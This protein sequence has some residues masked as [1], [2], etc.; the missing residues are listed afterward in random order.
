MFNTLTFNFIAMKKLL[1]AFLFILAFIA[2][3]EDGENSSVSPESITIESA[4]EWLSSNTS[5]ARIG[6]TTILNDDLYWED[7]IVEKMKGEKKDKVVVV[8]VLF[9]RDSKLTT[10]KQIWIYDNN[11]GVRTARI[12]E[13][14]YETKND[15]KNNL[16]N[17]SGVLVVRDLDGKFLGGLKIK[18]NHIEGL[19]SE[20]TTENGKKEVIQPK[21]E[22]R[23][24]VF[25]CGPAV[26]CRNWTISAGM[27]SWT[28]S[29]CDADYQCWWGNTNELDPAFT[30][31]IID[32]PAIT[33]PPAAPSGDPVEQL[34]GPNSYG[35][36]N[37]I[38]RGYL[39]MLQA[40]R[41][42]NVEIAGAVTKMGQVFMFPT[43]GNDPHN[44]T[45]SDMYTKGDGQIIMRVFVGNPDAADPMNDG[46]YKEGT[47]Y[48]EMYNYQTGKN[49]NWEVE[50]FVHTHPIESGYDYHNP[51][52]KDLSNANIWSESASNYILT[53]QRLIK[54]TASGATQRISTNCL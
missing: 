46:K 49:M 43:K 5:G 27:V 12:F 24:N 34:P 32:I 42:Q 35:Y 7:A 50:G 28:G 36:A 2:C 4:K 54:Y 13:Y 6:S 40:Q 33:D 31:Y 41:E 14:V 26:V 23:T 29:N 30:G 22:A 18:K 20:I 25:L 48:V 37:D 51:S 9:S 53:E 52:Q 17:F 1:I 45:V 19:I 8:P 38:C 44:Y 3:Q 21:K 15:F 10:L 11:R 47:A 16:K 39:M